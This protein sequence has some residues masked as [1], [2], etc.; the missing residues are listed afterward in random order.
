MNSLCAHNA[1]CCIHIAS[2]YP[3][4]SI[5]LRVHG[6]TQG[7][8]QVTAAGSAVYLSELLQSE[9]GFELLQLLTDLLVVWHQIHG[10]G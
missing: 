5:A 3:A 7:F 9:E 10:M 8:Q 1:H 4:I 2:R 6:M